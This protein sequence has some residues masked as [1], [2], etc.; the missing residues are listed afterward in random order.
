[1]STPHDEGK[2]LD[3]NEVAPLMRTRYAYDTH[4]ALKVAELAARRVSAM[5]TGHE[6]HQT[7][8]DKETSI[9][10]INGQFLK[11]LLL[12]K[13][14]ITVRKLTFRRRPSIKIIFLS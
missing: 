10:E 8:D 6:L 9:K 11:Q 2:L 5:D 7:G 13:G 3:P 14:S 12:R 4:N 1:M